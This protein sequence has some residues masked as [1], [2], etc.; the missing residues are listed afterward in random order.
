MKTNICKPDYNR[1]LVNLGNSVLKYFGLPLKH[2]SLPEL[3]G[4][5]QGKNFR[6]VILLLLDGMG[7]DM[8]EKNLPADSFL[9]RHLKCN[10]S[11]VFPSTTTAA[12]TSLYSAQNPIE[13]GFAGWQCY[14]KEYHRHI[15]LFR[16]QDFYTC[17]NLPYSVTEEFLPYARLDEQIR[18]AGV[19]KAYG[20]A[21]PWGDFEIN[22]FDDICYN[23][24]RLAAEDD[25]KFILSY[26]KQPDGVMHKTGCYSP[27]TK[28]VIKELN[29][30]LE[31][32][33]QK[34]P[35]TL[36]IITADHGL[37]DVDKTII[38][39]DYPDLDAC[40]RLRP[41]IETRTVA[42]YVK[43]DSL[44]I[45]PKIFNQYFGDQFQL[46]TAE[47]FIS[48]GYLGEGKEHP[49]IRDFLGDFVALGTGD[50]IMLYLSEALS[51]I[52]FVAQHA[53]LAEKEM[54]IPLIIHQS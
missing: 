12:T 14:F 2:P 16:K 8:L 1:C 17:E 28:A 18:N 13:H 5:L 3:D 39:N 46:L 42:F 23:L 44:H 9:R 10:I 19:V 45:F 47:E 41:G 7:V 37:V 32:L 33:S 49:K 38:L 20:V 35:D 50:S 54:C 29:D 27:E 51:E 40:L 43:P 15:V 6:T 48:Q 52:S 22:S 26:W 31:E 24:R 11:S 25:K 21:Q 53:G 30:K 36:L 4:Y 34:L